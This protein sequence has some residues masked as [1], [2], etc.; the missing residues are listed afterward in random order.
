M[1]REF[2]TDTELL[3][4]VAAF[5]V[6]MIHASGSGSLAGI[7]YDGIARF[8]VPVFVISS[9]YYMLARR[10]DGR[11]L[12]KKCGRLFL[13]LLVWSAIYYGY[14]LLCGGTYG[15]LRELVTYLLTQPV[16][17]WYLYAAMTLYLFTPMLY[18]FCANAT[19]REE[20][21][22]LGVTFLLGSVVL[23][24]LRADC[25]AVL[26]TVIDKMKVPYTLG[27]VCLYLLGD[28]LRKYD[29]CRRTRWLLYAAGLLGTAFT[30]LGTWKL[31]AYGMPSDLLLSFF[32]PNVMAAGAAVF[33]LIRQLYARR[34][35]RS[36]RIRAWVHRLADCTLGIYLLHPLIL[37][38]LQRTVEPLLLSTRP[39]FLI[40][41]R[42]VLAFLLS[43]ILV[44]LIRKVPVLK[45][46]T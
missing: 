43:A 22:A 1:R 16:H 41:Q 9:G 26:A 8:S 25:S 2:D 32:A 21:Y 31:P 28:Y 10:Q 18:V 34:P 6:V 11:K 38:I 13:L 3:R 33:V 19:R 40:P 23:I 4:I 46:L 35:I 30:V 24:L 7:F 37:Q 42:T 5:F 20:R 12:A 15:G 17:L 39:C 45:H 14:N 27:F 29:L 44:Y 36:D